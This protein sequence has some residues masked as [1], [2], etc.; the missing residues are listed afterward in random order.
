MPQELNIKQQFYMIIKKFRFE[1]L[2]EYVLPVLSELS[3]DIIKSKLVKNHE[4]LTTAHAV[5]IIQDE[6]N[7][8]NLSSALLKEYLHTLEVVEISIHYRKKYWFAYE[9]KGG[10]EP[11]NLKSREI[12]NNIK[13]SFD[14]YN[15]DMD[16]KA[17]KNDNLIFLSIKEKLKK[18]QRKTITPTYFA[19]TRHYNFFFCSKEKCMKNILAAVI[20]GLNYKSCKKL[21]LTGRD[22]PS[23][24]K[25]LLNKKNAALQGDVVKDPLPYRYAAPVKTP[26]GLDFTQNKN[27]E[28]Y[29]EKCFGENPPVFESL[30]VK[31]LN[32]KWK[33]EKAA[34]KLPNASISTKIE[35]RSINIPNFLK[36]LVTK[37]ILT[38]PLP[39]YA[40]NV[41][42]IGRNDM[43]LTNA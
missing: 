24:V 38:T 34:Q 10:Q 43:E 9:L 41:L 12:E 37:G 35:F 1:E 17:L 39:V 22:V 25:M 42:N 4:S 31:C 6:I 27:R 11:I 15:M 29:A 23:L 20:D 36:T 26:F 16:V 5:P 28:Q 32:Q 19:L 2:E 14:K 7:K 21:K 33:H 13:E 18:K 30:K 40:A 3:W 8:A